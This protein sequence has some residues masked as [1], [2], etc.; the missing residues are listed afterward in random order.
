[1]RINVFN[2][3]I[4][5][6]INRKSVDAHIFHF[7]GVMAKNIFPSILKEAL[8]MA[9]AHF[10]EQSIGVKFDLQLV[11]LLAFVQSFMD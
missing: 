5:D 10:K 6:A 2:R 8:L 3:L 9:I 11:F 7:T 4:I 1:M